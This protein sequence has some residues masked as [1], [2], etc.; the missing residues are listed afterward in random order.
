VGFKQKLL[1]VL[2]RIYKEEQEVVAD[3]SDEE[4]SAVGTYEQWSVKDLMAHI[5]A[6]K[7]IRAESIAATSRGQPAPVIRDYEE[8]NAEIFEANKD[9]SWDDMLVY[10]QRA[11]D[12]LVESLKMVPEADLVC[13]EPS[14]EQQG[15]PLWRAIEGVGC[16]HPMLHLAEHYIGRGQADR[17]VRFAEEI[18]DMLLQ[19][20]DSPSWRGLVQYNLACEYATFGQQEMAIAQLREALQLNP[21]LTEWSREDPDLVSI[22][23]HP[24]CQGLYSD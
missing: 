13:A 1:R 14:E 15:R 9:R 18:S 11:Y 23:E 21:A 17:G 3:L 8:A 16:T 2:E 12:S 7:E 20:D 24:D 19:L 4:R 10:L 22:R 5:A 6:W